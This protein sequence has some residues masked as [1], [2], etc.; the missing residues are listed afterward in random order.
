MREALN[1]DPDVKKFRVCLST[2]LLHFS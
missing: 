2:L 1:L